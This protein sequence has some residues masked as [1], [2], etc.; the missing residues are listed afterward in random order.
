VDQRDGLMPAFGVGSEGK[1]ENRIARHPRT[2]GR[3]GIE[4]WTERRRTA[5]GLS[6]PRPIRDGAIYPVSG[7]ASECALQGRA[8][9]ITLG[10]KAVAM[11]VSRVSRRSI[12]SVGGRRLTHTATER[13]Y[14]REW[15]R[16]RPVDLSLNLDS[17]GVVTYMAREIH[18]ST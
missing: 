15:A 12:R 7:V 11:T 3:K 9:V 16:G 18:Q 6:I 5:V 4:E 8:G 10:L 1:D 14:G 2:K 13:I 17:T